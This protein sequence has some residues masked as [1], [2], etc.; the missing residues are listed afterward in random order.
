MTTEPTRDETLAKLVVKAHKWLKMME[1]GQYASIRALA[2]HEEI[3][4]SYLARVLRLTLLAPSIV[5]AIMDGC[6]P[7]CLTCRELKKPFSSD[8]SE[9]RE[10]WSV[11]MV[12]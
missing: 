9:Q 7:D 1:S 2:E 5:E 4:E 8:W 6:H 12:V 3:D 11:P 10:R